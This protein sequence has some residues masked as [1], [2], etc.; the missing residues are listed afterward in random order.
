[1]TKMLEILKRLNEPALVRDF[2]RLC[3]V[4][5]KPTATGDGHGNSPGKVL[6]GSTDHS[7]HGKNGVIKAPGGT[8]CEAQLKQRSAASEA[9]RSDKPKEVQNGMRR[10]ISRDSL[11]TDGPSGSEEEGNNG[12]YDIENKF[13]YALFHFGANLG[14]ELFYILF[15]PWWFWNIDG[16]VGRRLCLFW[17]LFMYLGQAA[18]DIIKWPRPASPPVVRMEKRY[19]LEYGMP[20]THSM[21]GAGVP[22]GILFLTYG[23]YKYDFGICCFGATLWCCLVAF[24]RLYLGM[25]SILDVIAGLLFVFSLMPVVL[26]FMDAIDNAILTHPWSPALC[27]LIPLVMCLAYPTLDRWSTARGDTTLILAVAAGISVGHWVS[28]QYGFM[29][30]APT[31][32]PYDIIPPTWQWFGEMLMRLSI[33][34]VILFSTRAVFKAMT[35]NATCWLAGVDRRDKAAHQNIRIELPCKFITYAAIAFNTVYLAPQVFRYLGIERET[36]FTEI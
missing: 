28:F 3:G 35:L 9:K 8:E 17:A 13:L 2:Q 11:E 20:S 18:K 32:P 31:S 30:K 27:L 15:F 36:F 4:I 25:H 29:H 6:K 14:N 24:S 5:L 1:M 22:F 33:G 26:P 10:N 21:V 34:V 12:E 23:R 19:A 16:Y 7:I